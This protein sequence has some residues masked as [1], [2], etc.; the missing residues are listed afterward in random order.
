M[1][2]EDIRGRYSEAQR[3]ITEQKRARVLRYGTDAD[4][5][6]VRCFDDLGEL[7]GKQTVAVPDET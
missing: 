6:L 2:E 3:L 7:L 1:D 4:K 5:L